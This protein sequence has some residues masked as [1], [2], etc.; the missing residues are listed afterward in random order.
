[1]FR[2]YMLGAVNVKRD[3]LVSFFLN[4]LIDDGRFAFR[5][6]QSAVFWVEIKKFICSASDFPIKDFSNTGKCNTKFLVFRSQN[7]S[8][9]RTRESI[10]ERKANTQSASIFLSILREVCRT[11]QLDVYENI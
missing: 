2:F 7:S 10:Q 11:S 9:F 1:M 8:L 5:K 6:D 3:R 4:G